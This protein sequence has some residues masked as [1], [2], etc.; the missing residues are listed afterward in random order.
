MRAEQEQAAITVA[1]MQDHLDQRS[2]KLSSIR[3]AMTGAEAA[4]EMALTQADQIMESFRKS[5]TQ[6]SPPSFAGGF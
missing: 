4:F 5:T 2:N 6:Q 1:S 3:V